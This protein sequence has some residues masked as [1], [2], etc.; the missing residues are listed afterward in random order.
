MPP[1]DL[2]TNEEPERASRSFATRRR[3]KR[4][5]RKHSN[6]YLELVRRVGRGAPRPVDEA[7]ALVKSM[8]TAGFDETIEVAVQLGVD[9]RHG[10]QAVRGTTML[11]HGTG[12]GKVVWVFARGDAAAAATAAGADVVGAEDL[13][14]RI[15]KAGGAE[16]DLLVAAPDMMVLLRPLG[17]LLKAKMPNPKSGTV[18]AAPGDIVTEVKKG[19]RTEYRVEKAGIIHSSIGKASFPDDHLRDNL[20]ALLLALIKSKPPTSK[21]KYLRAI[22]VSSSMSP[23]VPVD[24][25]AAQK[26][27]GRG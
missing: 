27:T 20:V 13:V 3:E 21:G 5:R 11:P 12:K 8:A 22:S 24:T 7:I 2:K 18:T 14:E 4:G 15:Q 19:T 9:P 16:C 25:V 1:E 10:E 6:R 23:G 26:L 17:Q